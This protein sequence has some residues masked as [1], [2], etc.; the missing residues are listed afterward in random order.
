MSTPIDLEDMNTRTIPPSLRT[1][2]ANRQ[3]VRT[4]LLVV[5]ALLA[6][7]LAG[8][9]GSAASSSMITLRVWYSTDDPGER[10]WSQ[11]LAQQYERL[12][13]NV[14]VQLTDFSFEDLNTKLQLA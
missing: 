6:I 2:H 7:L 3:S 9:G 12:H 1:G 11:G 14:H 4:S 13:P 10:T 5:L 8:C